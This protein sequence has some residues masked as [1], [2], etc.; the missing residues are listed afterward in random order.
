MLSRFSSADWNYAILIVAAYGIGLIVLSA[1]A[2]G[3]V[4]ARAGRGDPLD[5]RRGKSLRVPSLG[6]ASW[7]RRFIALLID[8]AVLGAVSAM[9]ALAVHPIAGAVVLCFA[10]SIYFPTGYGAG[11]TL[12]AVSTRIRIVNGRGTEPGWYSGALRY[13][14]FF[15]TMFPRGRSRLGNGGPGGVPFDPMTKQGGH[16]KIAGTYVVRIQGGGGEPLVR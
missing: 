4:L 8:L 12:G 9:P 15:A 7:P 14:M 16:D 3:V 11:S 5:I 1:V 13:L 6:F 10:A 2:L